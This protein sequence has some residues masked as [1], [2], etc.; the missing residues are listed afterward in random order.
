MEGKSVKQLVLVI[1]LVLIL[2]SACTT[3]AKTNDLQP[4]ETISDEN[5]EQYQSEYTELDSSQFPVRQKYFEEVF[6]PKRNE[7][8]LFEKTA[9]F[10]NIPESQVPAYFTLTSEADIFA[11][12]PVVASD[13]SEVAY[14]LAS[15]RYFSL[16]LLDE[17]Y[18]KQPEFYPKFKEYGLSYWTEP[19]SSSWT[20]N[21]YGSYPSE[22]WDTLTIG[23][24]EEFSGVAFFHTSWGVQTYQGL[25]IVPTA[26]A[27]KYFDIQITP[28]TFLLH[29][30]F[31]KFSDEWA[32]KI[33]I[34]GKR[35]K[36]TQPGDYALGFNV[37]DPPVE[38]AKEWEGKYR[39]LYFSAANAIK[40]SGNTINFYIKV[41]EEQT[42]KKAVSQPTVVNSSFFR[43]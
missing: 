42:D 15:G 2:L 13:F 38:M 14:L 39:N 9:L 4:E 6:R 28:D 31:P 41:Q 29:P 21:G 25:T 10:L 23:G 30:V 17:A 40:P 3:P 32:Y 19:K 5:E 18:Y 16:E 8:K 22:Q 34:T 33:A 7:Y 26:D 1:I 37:V 43:I 24:R 11:D 35:K 27:E 36:D 20:V 12:L